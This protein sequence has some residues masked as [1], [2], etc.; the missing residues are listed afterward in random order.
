MFEDKDS[1]IIYYYDSESVQESYQDIASE[2][3]TYLESV[4]LY[5]TML[6]TASLLAEDMQLDVTMPYIGI[7]GVVH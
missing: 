2:P 6:M 7:P 5:N 3:M 1:N 4:D